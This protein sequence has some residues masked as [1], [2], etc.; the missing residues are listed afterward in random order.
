MSSKELENLVNSGLLK[1]ASSDRKEF[2]GLLKSGQKRLVDAHNE[3][4]SPESRFDLAYNAAH[5]FS[6]AAMRWHGYRADKRF[7]V[8]Q[9]LVHT[10]GLGPEVWR[11]L[12]KCHRIRNSVEYEGYVVFDKQLL[13]DLL[14]ATEKVRNA[15]EKL[16]P[17]RDG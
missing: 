12:D 15:V 8:F 5:A 9:S 1:V 2:N 7:V 6:L 14:A 10:L 16:G 17:I 13:I 4:L 11:V 3:D